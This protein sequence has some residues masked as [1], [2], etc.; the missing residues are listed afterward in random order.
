VAEFNGELIWKAWK[1]ITGGW[2]DDAKKA[3]TWLGDWLSKPPS[4]EGLLGGISKII[5]GILKA[6]QLAIKAIGDLSRL[7]FGDSNEAREPDYRV[8][9]DGSSTLSALKKAG[10]RNR[11]SNSEIGPLPEPD[12][13]P[14]Q[15]AEPQYGPLASYDTFAR[16]GERDPRVVNVGG[17]SVVVQAKTDA[18]PEDMA[19][20]AGKEFDRR[21]R[22]SLDDL[23]DAAKAI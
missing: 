3:W 1:W 5:W 16:N 22:Q 20:E 17:I 4:G 2:I 6:T 11:N 21:V 14:R 18:S 15:I 19:R 12:S 10:A 13:T 9:G 23:W 7:M 8:E